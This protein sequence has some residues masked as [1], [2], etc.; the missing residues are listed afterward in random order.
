[1]SS[2]ATFALDPQAPTRPPRLSLLVSVTDPRDP[3]GVRHPL[4]VV[5]GLGLAAVLAGSR[6]FAAIGQ[7]VADQP[8]QCLSELGLTGTA[9]PN[10]SAIRRAFARLDADELDRVLGAHL[11]TRTRQAGARVWIALDGKTVR[12]ACTG[13]DVAPHLVAGFDHA[14]GAVLGQVSVS[15]KSNEIPAARTPAG[16]VRPE[17]GR[18]HPRCDA[19]PV[20]HRQ[21]DHRHRRRLRAHGQ[22]ELIH[23]I[24]G[25]LGCPAAC[26]DGPMAQTQRCAR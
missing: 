24:A 14:A 7:W 21:S 10:E 5:L 11:W 17:P 4:P 13:T 26:Y 1:M 25:A 16:L 18:G 15:A 19:H 22:A 20:R 6:S 2:S 3:R 23:R 8:Q 9:R 12:G